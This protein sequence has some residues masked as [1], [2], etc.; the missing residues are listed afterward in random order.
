MH[1]ISSVS[2]LFRAALLQGLVA[3]LLTGVIAAPV[4]ERKPYGRVCIGVVTGEIEAPFQASSGPGVDTHI[5]V[6]VDAN[7]R[8]QVLVFAFNAR[9]GKLAPR[10]IPLRQA[11]SIL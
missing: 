5:F 7:Q 11:A 2:R 3:G 1:T 6:H 8:C 4:D 10:Y 9:D